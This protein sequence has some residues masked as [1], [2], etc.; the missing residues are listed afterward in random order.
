[1]AESEPS[2]QTTLLILLGASEWPYAKT[3]A[4]SEAFAKSADKVKAYFRGSYGL[5]NE[6]FLDLFNTQNYVT[7]VDEKIRG[8]LVDRIKKMGKTDLPAR[9][10]V[11]YYRGHGMFAEDQMRTYSLALYSSRANSVLSSAFSVQALSNALKEGARSLRRLVI[12]D[13]CF[14]GEAEKFMQADASEMAV[15]QTEHFFKGSSYGGSTKN[16]VLSS[17]LPISVNALDP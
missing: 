12:L 10:L 11:F 15:R 13:S 3:L 4:A 5:P 17:R 6:N 16:R 9:D 2:H 8:F 14:A 1:M 7:E